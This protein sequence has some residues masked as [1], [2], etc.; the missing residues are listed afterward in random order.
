MVRA[1][2]R[3]LCIALGC[4]ETQDKIVPW[5]KPSGLID[6]NPLELMDHDEGTQLLL[7]CTGVHIAAAA[8]LMHHAATALSP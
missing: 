2:H 7:G 4:E 6:F 3:R 1:C 5:T 8:V